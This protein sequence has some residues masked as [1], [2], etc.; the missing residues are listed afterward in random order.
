[1]A[2]YDLGEF[3]QDLSLLLPGCPEV[4]SSH[5]FGVF[6]YAASGHVTSIG[7]TFYEATIPLSVTIIMRQFGVLK[8]N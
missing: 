7:N 8:N 4:S 5:R 2:A 3:V 1:M 6:P